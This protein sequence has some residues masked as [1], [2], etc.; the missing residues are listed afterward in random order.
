[1][2][3]QEFVAIFWDYENCQPASG[4]SGYTVADYIRRIALQFGVVTVF[5]AYLELGKT[6]PSKVKTLLSELQSSG[7]SLIDCP[8]NGCKEVADKMLLV[9]VMAH[10]IDH[11]APGTIILISGDRDFVYAVSTLRLRRYQVVVIASSQIHISLH[12]QASLVYAW[13]GGKAD[14]M[15]TT[16]LRVCA[17]SGSQDDS[18]FDQDSHFFSCPSTS[19]STVQKD[20]QGRASHASPSTLT[21]ATISTDYGSERCLVEDVVRRP[22]APVSLGDASEQK[23]SRSGVCRV[24]E[25]GSP[26]SMLALP[27]DLAL[28]L[29]AT[30]CSWRD[31]QEVV[32]HLPTSTT[33]ALRSVASHDDTAVHKQ[34]ATQSPT[35]A[36]PQPRTSSFSA[37]TS[38]SSESFR[39][40]GRRIIR[41]MKRRERVVVWRR[42]LTRSTGNASD[43]SDVNTCG[44]EEFVLTNQRFAKHNVWN[45]CRVTL[46][47]LLTFKHDTST[48]SISLPLSSSPAFTTASVSSTVTNS[49]SAS[50]KLEDGAMNK[51]AVMCMPDA[52]KTSVASH[53]VSD[54]NVVAPFEVEELLHSPV[55][56]STDISSLSYSKP[57]QSSAQDGDRDVASVTA[58]TCISESTLSK[59]LTT[60]LAPTSTLTAV[61]KDERAF[62]TVNSVE[63]GSSL[64]AQPVI[65]SEPVFSPAPS[66]AAIMTNLSGP[67]LSMV[68]SAT[69]PAVIRSRSKFVVLVEELRCLHHQGQDRPRR[70]MVADGLMRRDPLI[71]QRAGVSSAT[72]FD[73]YISL[74]V[75]AGVVTVG[76]KKQK[77]IS[78]NPAW[79]IPPTVP[80]DVTFVVSAHANA[81]IT[82]PN[83]ADSLPETPSVL[84]RNVPPEFVLLVERLKRLESKDV[85]RPFRSLVAADLVFENRAVYQRAGV[86][87]FDA[88]AALAAKAG[89]VTL[90]GE[91]LRTWISLKA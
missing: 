30:G 60:T 9:D 16:K 31:Q 81:L 52:H 86:N 19:R 47:S 75:Q 20:G 79:L 72:K 57:S 44:T 73:T 39:L 87:N 54:H 55:L 67:S 2:S 6:G 40:V 36:K 34:T 71:Y 14:S 63:I 11:P 78:L 46:V 64:V 83:A 74:A 25:G 42:R 7:V 76:G 4:S 3:S 37:G 82:S 77:W 8:H 12:R 51:S 17:E 41:N 85:S 48:G 59:T 61:A 15:Q 56:E 50:V 43:I 1:M 58:V 21:H 91:G 69:T 13:N 49:S 10:A 28:S 38:T 53:P 33:G 90:G 65:L 68:Q 80:D 32:D 35:G 26:Q 27:T 88:Y 23:L 45:K 18:L 29:S 66:N 70:S 62:T 5:K 84:T 22:V 24:L 89:L